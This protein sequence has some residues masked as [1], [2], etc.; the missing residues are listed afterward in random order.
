MSSLAGS[1]LDVN[2]FAA[3]TIAPA[4]LVSGTF[5]DPTGEFVDSRKVAAL[6]AWVTFVQSR[7]II[8]TSKINSRLRKRYLVPFVD[9]VPEIV[10]GWLVASVT[11][12]LYKRR[13][14]DPSDAQFASVLDDAKQALEE[15]TEAANSVD[16]LFDLPLNNFST[17]TGVQKGMPLV[18]S[19]T[20]PYRWYDAQRQPAL[21]DD[22][23][24][25]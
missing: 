21:D 9:P 20:S 11:P 13:G 16:G 19:E 6:A 7:L 18:Y 24:G 10:N 1:Y 2:G 5:I 3:R 23:I 22:G 8:E 17:A 4:S 12:L 14:I 15:M 25:P